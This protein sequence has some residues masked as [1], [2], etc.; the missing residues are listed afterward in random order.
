M[1]WNSSFID[2]LKMQLNIVDVIGRE[3]DIRKSGANYK[4]LCPFHN[5]KT[6]S[7]I[8]NEEKQIF[9]CFGCGEKGDV[10][11]FVQRYYNLS[12]MEAVEKLCD[13]Y[14]IKKPANMS[15]KADIDYSK[16]YQINAKA[17]RFF[18][19]QL[20]SRNN[21]GLEYFK[22]RGLSNEIIR[23]FGLGYAPNSFSALTDYLKSENIPE[24]D[25]L[26]LGL[27]NKGKN[28]L[29][30]KFRNRI[31]FPIINTRNKVIGFGARAIGDSI[32]K[33]LNSSE[34][35]VFIKKNNLF[36]LN[37]TNKEILD[38]DRAI[39]VEGYMDLISLYQHGIKNVTA[40]LG[41]ALTDNQAKL[42][43]RY[44]KNIVLSYDSD[45]AGI[46]A[47]IRGIDVLNNAG[48]KVRILIL[49]EGEDPDDFIRKSGKTEFNKLVD[50]AIPA[51]DFKLEIAKR[52]FS[53]DN[54]DDVLLYI[55]RVIP[56]LQSLGP[57][58]Q[59]IYI[60]KIAEEYNVSENAIGMSVRADIDKP[61][62]SG[63]SLFIKRERNTPLNID[64]KLEISF[65]FLILYNRTYL[66]RIEEDGI[67][68]HTDI[69]NKIL[70]FIQA[71]NMDKEKLDL[72]L[73]CKNLDPDDENLLLRYNDSI[74][75]G[76]D[77]EAF[78]KATLTA[79]M[80]KKY[81]E[82]KTEVLNSLA[83]A[84]VMKQSQDMKILGS[85]LIELDILINE[86]LEENHV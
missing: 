16:Y 55:E 6:P 72:A 25:I 40:T 85:R 9:N 39:I 74:H 20:T 33:Y 84:E 28:G 75:I 51:T 21:V 41:T 43:T 36:G 86:L 34:S 38:E 83:V 62:R 82:E 8:V 35:E 50:N 15:S 64:V 30:D 52:G 37:L 77:D 53:L 17:G 54:K 68:F 49:K 31:V 12:F 29:Y 3:V 1:S 26:K 22:Q 45:S 79:Y 69:A 14:G 46:S 80:I 66:K 57:I 19:S 4:A 27:A 70:S 18:Y 2:E 24:E 73:V 65:I 23:K 63:N 61:N 32:P 76:P 44:T 42:I 5:E 59:D 56:I 81:K 71:S 11:K 67:Q 60:K 10:I 13:E 47:A 58:E 7:F 78:Y 48:A